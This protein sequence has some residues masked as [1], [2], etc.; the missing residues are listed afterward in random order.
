MRLLRVFAC[1]CKMQRHRLACCATGTYV[2]YRLLLLLSSMLI[3]QNRHLPFTI[4][5]FGWCRGLVVK[6]LVF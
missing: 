2:N 4:Y 1:V 5:I 6:T 3:C